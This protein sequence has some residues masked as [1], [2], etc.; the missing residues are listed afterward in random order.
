MTDILVG[1]LLLFA[2]PFLYFLR[3]IARNLRLISERVTKA[4]FEFADPNGPHI[5]ANGKRQLKG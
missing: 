5:K 3:E 1:V 4:E 2:V